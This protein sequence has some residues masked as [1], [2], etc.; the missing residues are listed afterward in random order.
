MTRNPALRRAPLSYGKDGPL[1]WVAECRVPWEPPSSARLAMA[2]W[3]ISHGSD[4][5]HGGDGPL[6]HREL[7]ARRAHLQRQIDGRVLPHH[8]TYT[9]VNLRRETRLGRP[10]LIIAKGQGNEPVVPAG[11]RD[12]GA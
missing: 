5:H 6:M 8:E 7:L 2:E 4:V 3:T 9:L 10:D 1:T 12:R 11:V